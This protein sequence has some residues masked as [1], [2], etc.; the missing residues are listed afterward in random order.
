MQALSEL[1]GLKWV[2]VRPWEESSG[3][4]SGKVKTVTAAIK[5]IAVLIKQPGKVYDHTRK[6][7]LL[8]F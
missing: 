5:I 8:M 6:E 2:R 7:K 4:W 1:S 3:G